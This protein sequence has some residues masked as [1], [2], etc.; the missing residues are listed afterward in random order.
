MAIKNVGAIESA[1]K[2]EPG[3]LQKAIDNEEEVDVTI[4]ELTIRTLEE[5]DTRTGNLKTQYHTAGMEIAIKTARDEMGLEFQG[6]TMANF[7]DAVSKKALEG[8]NIEPNKK[9]QELEADKLKLQE[10]IT[11]LEGVI[12]EKDTLFKKETQKRTIDNLIEKNITGE[13]SLPKS[14]VSTLFKSKYD[15]SLDETDKLVI[16]KG[17]EVLK[18]KTTLS[19]LGIDE[20]MKDFLPNYTKKVQ[21]GAAGGDETGGKAGSMEAF[22]KEMEA[23]GNNIGSQPYNEELN[24]RIREKTLSV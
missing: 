6:K 15:V 17:G 14:D 22:N 23:Q 24:K 19:N 18:N 9:I 1:F 10:N 13:L 7:A 11:G 2:L 4:P 20:V 3:S 16:S 21:G 5:D 12:S 8:A